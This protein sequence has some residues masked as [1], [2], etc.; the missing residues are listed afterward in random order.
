MRQSMTGKIVCSDECNQFFNVYSSFKI[1]SL[2]VIYRTFISIHIYSLSI[3]YQYFQYY[4]HV[5]ESEWNERPFEERSFEVCMQH[6]D[7][8]K[9][10]L[11]SRLLG[12]I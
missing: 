5:Q 3:Q 9:M 2:S 1:I 8:M 10:L 12:T 7:K 4:L 11:L 6:T